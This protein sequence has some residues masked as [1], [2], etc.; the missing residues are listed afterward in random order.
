[1]EFIRSLVG[2]VPH[3]HIEGYANSLKTALTVGIQSRLTPGF[4]QIRIHEQIFHH[5]SF[6]CTVTEMTQCNPVERPQLAHS[7]VGKA[8]LA[9]QII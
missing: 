2:T 5:W 9:G 4:P 8:E 3:F 1:M 7:V 6:R